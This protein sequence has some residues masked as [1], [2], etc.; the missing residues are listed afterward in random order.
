MYYKYLISNILVIL[1]SLILSIK[2]SCNEFFPHKSKFSLAFKRSIV[3]PSK[4]D[5][6]QN[7]YFDWSFFNIYSKDTLNPDSIYNEAINA[8]YG[9]SDR[10]YA[11]KLLEMNVKYNHVYS[12]EF[13]GNK[14]L[15]DNWALNSEDTLLGIEYLNKAILSGSLFSYV[16]LAEFYF[17]KN[18]YL[19]SIN[20][21]ELAD[22]LGY[23]EA[24]YELYYIYS[25]GS[26][27]MH[28][29]DDELVKKNIIDIPKSK[30]YLQKAANQNHLNAMID[31]A[32]SYQYE[33]G[34]NKEKAKYY[35]VKIFSLKFTD[36]D[37]EGT[38]TLIYNLEE[39]IAEKYGV[40]WQDSLK[41]WKEK[42][43]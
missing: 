12:L 21:L 13:L 17:S 43:H 5:F 41:V 28:S 14:L 10:E 40:S 26:T 16:I 29:F 36:N 31:L 1:I 39:F 9:L 22:S 23:T 37:D 8:Y 20:N 6:L 42:F 27:R 15:L 34:S 25:K 18:E 32:T 19:K 35:Y 4:I 3:S 2:I 30:Y 38:R 24:T 33:N 11:R 7:Q